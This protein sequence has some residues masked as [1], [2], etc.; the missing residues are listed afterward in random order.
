M[1]HFEQIHTRDTRGFHITLSIGYEEIH[2]RDCFD[3]SIDD[4]AEIC[5]KIDNGTY[6]WFVARVEAYKA[7]I[8]LATDYLG[9]NLYE[10]PKDFIN[11]CNFEDMVDNVVNEATATL[12]KLYAAR[13]EVIT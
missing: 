5:R 3:D 12:E 13:D 6:T 8:L 11:D 2:P 7:G 9:A 1:K 4:I 10:N